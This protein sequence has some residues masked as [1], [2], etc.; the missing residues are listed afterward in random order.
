MYIYLFGYFTFYILQFQGDWFK[1]ITEGLQHQGMC[2]AW[3]EPIKISQ[4]YIMSIDLFVTTINTAI[5]KDKHVGDSLNEFFSG[6]DFLEWKEI[7]IS[8]NTNIQPKLST[9]K[10]LVHMQ[11]IYMLM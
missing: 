2:Q 4:E 6:V 8:W 11:W 3:H 10:V 1:E 5:A 9:I 7:K